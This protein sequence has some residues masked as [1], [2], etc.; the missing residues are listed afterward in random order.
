MCIRDRYNTNLGR[1]NY[2]S[3]QVQLTMRP[4]M[5]TSFQGTYTWAKSM[6]IPTS[7]YTDPLMRNLD[8][9]KGTE[10]AHTYRMN[11][12]FELPIGPNKLLFANSS[13][14][15]A[16]L[17]ENWQTSFILNL[18][19]GTPNSIFGAGTMRYG[20]ARY[21]ATEHWKTP[22][23]HVEWNGPNGTGTYF[24]VSA[25]GVIGSYVAVP[26]PQCADASQ[27]AQIDSRGFSYASNQ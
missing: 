22:K 23:G 7:G 24:G 9:V 13:G 15:V 12:T 8:R 4:V 25:P 20:N 18:A 16:R 3:M 6:R 2:H 5:G 17:I 19:T 14:W 1:Q 21:V 11:G 26:D 27:V 10:Q